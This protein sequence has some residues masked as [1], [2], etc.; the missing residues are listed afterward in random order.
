[1]HPALSR[2]IAACALSALALAPSLGQEAPRAAVAEVRAHGG[3]PTLFVDGQPRFAMMLMA[4]WYK[5]EATEQGQVKL[6][7]EA[8]AGIEL[9]STSEELSLADFEKLWKAP[10]IYDFTLLDAK[11]QAIATHNPRAHIF[12]KLYVQPP[13][14]W[15][16]AHRTEWVRYATGY[17]PD[18]SKGIRTSNGEKDGT[19]VSFA[20]T[21]WREDAAAMVRAVVKHL[22]E[23]PLGRRVIGINLLNGIAQEWHY[24]GS[25]HGLHADTSGPMT[26]RFRTW[27]RQKYAGDVSRLRAAWQNPGISFET[28][29]VPGLAPRVKTTAG[30]FRDPTREMPMIDYARCQQEVTAEALLHCCRAVKEASR[31]RLLAGAY[32]G[33]LLH[34][35]WYPD[36]QSLA[37]SQVLRSPYVDFLAAP[38]N[39]TDWLSR[40]VGG[41]AL[42]RGLTEA[43]KAH[44][45][46]WISESDEGTYKADRVHRPSEA[47]HSWEESVSNLRKQ[48]ARVLVHGV[49]QWWWDWEDNHGLYLHPRHVEALREFKRIGDFSLRLDRSS[50]SEVALVYNLESYYYTSV[51]N[52]LPNWDQTDLLPHV[53]SRSGIPFDT[54][55]EEE[56]GHPNLPR[57]KLYLFPRSFYATAERRERIRQVLARD[58][59]TALWVYAP[60]LVDGT[61]LSLEAMR[62]LTGMRL[63][64][65]P[66]DRAQEI[67]LVPSQHPIT[68]GFRAAGTVMG[69][70]ISKGREN[71]AI[72]CRNDGEFRFGS[73][74]PVN[75]SF[76]VT[77]PEATVLG[78]HR[79]TNVPGLAVKQL[80]GWTSIY[81]AAV[82][83]STEL[84]RR[85]A[86][87]AGVHVYH[88][89][90]DVLM[91]GR[92]FL[93]FA[94]RDGSGR[95]TVR[96]PKPA[97][98]YDLVRKKWVAQNA[99]ELAIDLPPRS[100]ELFYYGSREELD[101]HFPK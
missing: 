78:V 57:Y 93:C 63:A 62:D 54:I 87:S 56:V 77:D 20:S 76:Y 28:A 12:L 14:W 49:G 40:G 23:S 96:L 32:Y 52:H 36:G 75:P 50:V 90:D 3:V 72:T 21:V 83:T 29:P 97:S 47:I 6:R 65:T 39:Y 1:M 44:G 46:L 16:E 98:V 5:H 79:G 22:E 9:H 4:P 100:T 53:L 2:S 18:R 94:S 25:V 61:R 45:K 70:E 88:D 80:D 60:G 34:T 13:R 101:R 26:Q 11:L 73:T 24:W 48:F 33:Y 99:S 92:H 15:V 71:A 31:N 59:A 81:S 64:A 91:I 37:L 42:L 27:L 17:V 82:P 68:A 95:R 69:M 89:R 86:R 84:L 58:R 43:C 41:D 35:P 74:R 67:T 8:S 55:T 85:I 30:F 10:G 7:A 66:G 51:V 19:F 38:G